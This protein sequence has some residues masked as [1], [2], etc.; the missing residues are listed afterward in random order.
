[1]TTTGPSPKTCLFLS[2]QEGEAGLSGELLFE[3][4]SLKSQK[5]SSSY[6]PQ[7]IPECGEGKMGQK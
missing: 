5:R 6:E 7:A 1:M 4:K 3:L 2:L